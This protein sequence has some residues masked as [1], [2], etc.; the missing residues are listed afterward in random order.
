MTVSHADSGAGY[1]GPT[2]SFLQNTEVTDTAFSYT[3]KLRKR[4]QNTSQSVDIKEDRLCGSSM[5]DCKNYSLGNKQKTE[6][7]SHS[8]C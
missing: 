6:Y 5:I 8:R 7:K 1:G 3:E 2:S 4:F